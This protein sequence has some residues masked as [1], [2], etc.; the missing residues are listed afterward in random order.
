MGRNRK[1]QDII[2]LKFGKLTV[3][4]RVDDKIDQKSGRHRFM[5]E[6]L[7]DCGNLKVIDKDQLIRTGPK[8]TISCGCAKGVD[9]CGMHDT[10]IHNVWNS[11]IQRCHNKNVKTYDRYGG[12]GIFVCDEWRYSFESFYNW[13]ISNGYDESLGLSIDRINNDLG[14]SPD[15]C[16]W[17]TREQQ[18]NNKSSN[19]MIT[20]DGKTLNLKQWSVI[21][22]VNYKVLHNRL[23]YH[24]YEYKEIFDEIMSH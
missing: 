9:G 16:R 18:A 17:A 7:C 3:I 11:M 8:R 24:N 4:R 12:R 2:G 1:N 19:R 20:Y 22:G 5:Y 15:N 23:K 13:A 6:C 14:Y 21:L 10:K